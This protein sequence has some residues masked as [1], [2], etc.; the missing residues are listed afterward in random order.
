MR[1][2]P[3]ASST[4]PP[5]D[6]AVDDLGGKNG[7]NHLGDR[8]GNRTAIMLNTG[9]RIIPKQCLHCNI[10]YVSRDKRRKF[11]SQSCSAIA[12]QIYKRQR[13]EQNPKKMHSLRSDLY[14]ISIG[15]NIYC[16]HK[17]SATMTNCGRICSERLNGYY[18][19]N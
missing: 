11:C 4:R 9:C 16:S 17:C 1:S 12:T 2:A 8:L 10:V 3:L 7:W 18:Q 15:N 13:Y 14:H 19:E 6:H 5:I